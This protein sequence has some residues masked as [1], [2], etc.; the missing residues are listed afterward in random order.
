MNNKGHLK[1]SVFEVYFSFKIVDMC[2]TFISEAKQ[3]LCHKKSLIWLRRRGKS[4][5]FELKKGRRGTQLTFEFHDRCC[6][7]VKSGAGEDNRYEMSFP[8]RAVRPSLFVNADRV[9][10]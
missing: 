9:L 5:Y 3:H 4:K 2:G 6:P 8:G 1:C 10:D 7:V